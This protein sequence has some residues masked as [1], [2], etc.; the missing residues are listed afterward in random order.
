[1]PMPAPVP[2]FDINAAAFV[3]TKKPAG[4]SE[5]SEKPVTD[6]AQKDM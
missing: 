6:E 4:N 5:S 2:S 1:M 3:P